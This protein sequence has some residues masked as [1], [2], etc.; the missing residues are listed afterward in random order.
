MLAIYSVIVFIFVW[1]ENKRMRKNLLGKEHEM[2]RRMYEVSILKELGERIGYSLNV[3]KI[4]DVVTGS[5]RKLL[6]YSTVSYLILSDEGRIIFHCIVEES[7]NKKFIEDVESRMLAALTALLNREVKESEVDESISG[8]ITDET[9]KTTIQSFFNIPVVINNRPVGLLNVSSHK[10]GLYKEEEMMLLYTIMHQAS[11]AV[12]KLEN[13]LNLEKGKLNSMVESMADGVLMVDT[14]NRLLVINPT[15]QKMLG[16]DKAQPSIFDILGKLS[17]KMDLRTK[18]EESL[19]K[20]KLEVEEQLKL[21]EKVLRV[22]VS[23]VKDAANEPLGAVVLF[24]DITKEKSIE[25]MRE[26]FTSMMVH[27]LR[28]PL[29]GI[30][31]IANLLREDKIKNEQKKY[32]EFIELIVSNSS[33][34]LDLVNDLLDV[35]KLE[36]GKLQILRRDT[37]IPEV[38]KVRIQSF[39]SLAEENHLTLESK[40]EPGVAT[41]SLDENKIAQVLNNFLSNAIKFTKEGKIIVSALTVKK[42]ESF[43]NKVSSLGMIWPGIKDKT[44]EEDVLIL[45]VTDSGVGIAEEQLSK[46]FNKFTQLEESAHSEKKGTGLGL[47]ISKGIAE[48]HGGSV[49]VFSEV[50]KGSTFYC[51]LPI[52][53][54]KVNAT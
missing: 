32:Q 19:R 45:G 1:I 17:S 44:F 9:N 36:S 22:L 41:F 37:N 13:I 54:E 39:V 8:T 29:T 16:I 11:T 49:G 7:V 10:P 21:D 26:D 48:A 25:K 18:I 34:M 53:K 27:E 5:L 35:A 23:P 47:V 51:V 20:D 42:G 31:S 52:A 30:R 28:S 46:L 43:L 15:A 2:Q 24:H 12:S 3:Q 33:S 40:V 4:V 14:R 38:I 6:D 50:S